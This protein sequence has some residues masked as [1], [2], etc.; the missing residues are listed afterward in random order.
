MKFAKNK[1][2]A[3][4]ITLILMLAMVTS[5]IVIPTVQ[6]ASTAV[7]A[8]F[9]I[10]S[11]A[12]SPI[13]IGQTLYVNIFMTKPTRTS[14]M[15]GVGDNFENLT[16]VITAPDGTTETKGPMRA[17]GTGGTYFS[18]VPS[19]LGNYTLQGFYPGQTLTYGTTYNGLR[20]LASVSSIV[21]VVVQQEQL[22][23]QTTGPPLPTE[24]WSRPIYATN[25][26]WGAIG[27][28][29]FGLAAG[30]FSTTGKY[31]VTGNVDLYG[32]APNTGH[33]VWTKPSQFGGQPGTPIDANQESQYLSTSI[34]ASYFEPIVLN[35]VLYTTIYTSTAVAKNWTAIDLRTGE[36]LWVT[37]RGRTGSESLRMGQIYHWHSMQEYGSAALLWTSNGQVY[38]AMTG[39]WLANFTSWNSGTYLADYSPTT[40]EE[41]TLLSW[42]IVSGNLT[43]WNSTRAITGSAGGAL[44]V[45]PSGIINATRGDKNLGPTPKTIAG[46]NISLSIGAVTNEVILLRSSNTT[47]GTQ[48]TAGVDP[49]TGALLW[50]PLNQT[51]PI[52]EGIASLGARDGVYI[53][54][55][56]DRGEAYGYSLTTGLLLWG[57]LK[58]PGNAWSYIEVGCEIAYGNAYIW[59]YGGYVNAVNLQTGVINWTWT[60]KPA[61]YNTPYGIYPLWHFGTGSICD[62]KLFLA[63]GKMYDPPMSPGAERLAI[64]CTDGTLVWSE[65]GWYGRMSAA[66]ADGYMVQWNSYD[67]QIYTLGKGPTATTVSASPTV[68]VHGNSVLLQGMVTDESSGTKDSDR[69]ARF[70]QGVAAVSDASM[71]HWM[72]YVYMQQSRPTNATGVEVTLDTIDPNGNYVHIG[73][74]T[75]DASGAYSYMFTPEVS[76]KYTIIASFTGSESYWG[77][78]AETAVGVSEAPAT[79]TPLPV[80]AQL[81]PYEIYTIGIGVAIIAAVA[82]VG[83]MILRKLRPRP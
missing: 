32:T 19:Q 3:I 80:A 36:T 61:G 18:Y 24:Y 4:A 52:N 34:L 1:T 82:I 15:M 74:V 26:E 50:G 16:V 59:D 37:P 55:N 57:P 81:P 70:P 62:G 40:T 31:D 39:Q 49:R 33:I 17:D 30:S 14:G 83:L 71:S 44:N 28:N 22:P 42:R 60:P 13:G 54:H 75:S 2:I 76:G 67:K 9:L 51:I 10:L 21:T 68:S 29:W 6:S 46:N 56:K 48:I 64:N 77:S 35:G 69:I 53:L 11:A 47:Q 45:R 8:T 79:P 5:L 27:G 78:Y 23:P 65:L 12:P 66:H 58:L 38:D 25:Y 7:E 73:T 72:E 43:M 41:G 63:E 20:Y